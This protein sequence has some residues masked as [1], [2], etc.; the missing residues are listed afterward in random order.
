M[1]RATSGGTSSPRAR[2]ASSRPRPTGSSHASTPCPG[3]TRSLFHCRRNDCR[4]T[5]SRLPQRPEIRQ[6]LFDA[7]DF[8][9]WVLL[10]AA[11][12][13]GQI[14]HGVLVSALALAQ[15]L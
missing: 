6:L 1:A 3:T 14:V 8:L 9:P 7:P 10:Q 2:N 15:F 12:P 4:R 11:Q 13:V 5:G